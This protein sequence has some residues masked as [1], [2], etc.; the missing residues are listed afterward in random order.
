MTPNPETTLNLAQLRALTSQS[1]FSLATKNAVSTSGRANP[2]TQE[3][4]NE[5][6]LALPEEGIASSTSRHKH[7]GQNYCIVT[8]STALNYVLRHPNSQLENHRRRN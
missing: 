6:V 4:L 8:H 5:H 3:G 1:L 2:Q 7:V